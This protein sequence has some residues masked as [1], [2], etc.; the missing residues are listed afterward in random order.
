MGELSFSALTS[1]FVRFS[2]LFCSCLSAGEEL[3]EFFVP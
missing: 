3:L 1:A 2:K